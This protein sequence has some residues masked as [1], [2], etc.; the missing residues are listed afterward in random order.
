LAPSCAGFNP[1][2][3]AVDHLRLCISLTKGIRLVSKPARMFP[4]KEKG[5][6][7]KSIDFTPPI[8]IVSALRFEIDSHEP[9]LLSITNESS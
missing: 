4:Q 3:V 6:R 5:F 9:R 1:Y 7:K 2:R 8:T